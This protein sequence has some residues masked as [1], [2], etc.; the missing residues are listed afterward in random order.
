MNTVQIERTLAVVI[1][2]HNEAKTMTTRIEFCAVE[3]AWDSLDSLQQRFYD[4]E[5]D[6]PD[7]A[8][9]DKDPMKWRNELADHTETIAYCIC[10]DTLE[11][12][13]VWSSDFE[14]FQISGGVWCLSDNSVPGIKFNYYY[15]DRE[16]ALDAFAEQVVEKIPQRI[17][18]ELHMGHAFS[19]A[20][21]NLDDLNLG[22]WSW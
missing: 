15:T 10:V 4:R 5:D 2:G 22:P 16:V 13:G 1:E 7:P 17:T 20:D 12:I 11:G 3:G 8:F 21:V 6:L 19:E 9:C 14:L 18:E